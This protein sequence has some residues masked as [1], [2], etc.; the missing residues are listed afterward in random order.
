MTVYPNSI[1]TDK[2]LPLIQNGATEIAASTVN[3]VRDATLALEQALGVCPQGN[4]ADLTT[5]INISID[6]NGNIKAG[7][8]TA[9][10]LVSLPIYD[11]QVASNA[12]ILETKL[13]LIYSTPTLKGLIDSTNSTV[14]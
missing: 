12:N 13:A 3:G 11:F 8:L 4:L 1:D 6:A 7:A 9:A 5:R 14:S 2:E 10:G